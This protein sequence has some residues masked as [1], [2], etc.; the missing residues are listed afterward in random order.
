M[1]P[2]VAGFVNV[3]R[4]IESIRRDL[5]PR[6][7]TMIDEIGTIYPDAQSPQK[8]DLIPNSYWNA[9][10]AMF[11]FLYATLGLPVNIHSRSPRRQ[12]TR[13]QPRNHCS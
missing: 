8:A 5:A 9:S 12:D 7:M 10:G 2:Q 11:A 3:V 6:A 4:Y 1:F 13:G